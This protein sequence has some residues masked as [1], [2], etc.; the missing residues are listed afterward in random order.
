MPHNQ[1]YMSLYGLCKAVTNYGIDDL[2]PKGEISRTTFPYG[3]IEIIVNSYQTVWKYTIT[4]LS[5]RAE[6]IS[7][8]CKPHTEESVLSNSWILCCCWI[9]IKE[10]WPDLYSK[11]A[12]RSQTNLNS[13]YN[14]QN[15]RNI[16][17]LLE[18]Y[19]HD[20]KTG[21]L[22]AFG[23]LNTKTL[24]MGSNCLGLGE[25]LDLIQLASYLKLYVNEDERCDW[26]YTGRDLYSHIQSK[27]NEGNIPSNPEIDILSDDY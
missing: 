13:L 10:C 3:G 17:L 15:L 9:S 16:Y 1:G 25:K 27:F 14:I 11:V 22:L 6:L 18:E 8:D 20:L 12:E 7:G 2:I 23:I 19:D 24:R 26:A 21:Y 5:I 4:P